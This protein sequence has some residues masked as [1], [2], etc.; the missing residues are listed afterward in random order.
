MDPDPGPNATLLFEAAAEG[1]LDAR[2]RLLELVYDELRAIAAACLKGERPDHTLQATALANEAYVRLMRSREPTARTRQQFLSL[3]ATAMRRILVNHARGR[4]R[5]KRGGLRTRMPFAI[6]L[7]TPAPGDA[8]PI[9]V[10]ALEEAL[11]RLAVLDQRKAKLVE[12]RFFAGLGIDEAAEVLG[13]ARSVAAD[14]W[15]LARAWLAVQLERG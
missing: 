6:A 15:R 8:A 14:D 3:A 10:L 7:E 13:I 11:E 2:E 12:L 9:E 1:C 5:L 4:A